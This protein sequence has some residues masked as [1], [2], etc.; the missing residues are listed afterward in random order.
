MRPHE[1]RHDCCGSDDGR[2]EFVGRLSNPGPILLEVVLAA[3]QFPELAV[4]D[5]AA[6]GSNVNESR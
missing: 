5:T 4:S 2:A 6:H 3:E 1:G